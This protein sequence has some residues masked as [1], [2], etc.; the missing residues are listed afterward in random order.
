MLAPAWAGAREMAGAGGGKGGR[1]GGGGGGGGCCCVCGRGVARGGCCKSEGER[2]CVRARGW[3][4]GLPKSGGVACRAVQ[5]ARGPQKSMPPMP[6][7][8]GAAGAAS[9]LGASVMMHSAVVSSEATEAA[10]T[11]AVRTTC[12]ARRGLHGRGSERPHWG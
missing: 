10:S 1:S 4:G 3:V 11:R 7:M 5:R 9:G 12:D 8:P 6:P 2:V